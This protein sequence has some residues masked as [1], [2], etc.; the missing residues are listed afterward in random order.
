[1]PQNSNFCFW[2]GCD[3]KAMLIN[4]LSMGVD[5]GELVSLVGPDGAG[6]STVFRIITGFV[7]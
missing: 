7:S 6:K 5:K 3:D 1:M 4:E 2:T